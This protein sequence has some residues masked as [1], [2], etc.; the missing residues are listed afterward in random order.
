MISH[1]MTRWLAAALCI[2][3]LPWAQRSMAREAPEPGCIDLR[4]LTGG[5]R[6]GERALLIRSGGQDGARLT[7]D[8]ACAVFAEGLALDVLAHEGWACPGG[9]LFARGG[10]VTCPV[11]D[12]RRLSAS[13][14]SEALVVL[15]TPASAD[16]MLAP[17]QVRERHWRDI[18]GTT[19]QCVDARFLRGWE[20]DDEGLVVEVAPSRHAGNRHY[21]VTL[22]E[23]CPGLSNA[24]SIRLRS[25]NGGAAVC[26]RPGDQV[27][28]AGR[29]PGGFVL[30]GGPRDGGLGYGCEIR[31]VTP[32]SQE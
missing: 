22:M 25:R 1:G 12:M 4:E 31:Q 13:E 21:R 19:D 9:R 28:L 18:T 5:W 32:L 11:I 2:G 16:V 3:M 27:V 20:R 6:A 10:G 8:P 24:H 7:L 15:E 14:L 29:R 26:G 17:V 23:T 30:Q